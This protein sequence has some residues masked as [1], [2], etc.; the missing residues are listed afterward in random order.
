MVDEQN[1]KT[2]KII[3]SYN[4]YCYLLGRR[5]NSNKKNIIDIYHPTKNF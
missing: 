4:N 1:E 5:R 3:V 2:K